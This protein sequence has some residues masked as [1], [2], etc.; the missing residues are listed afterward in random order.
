M[1]ELPERANPKDTSRPPTDKALDFIV[2]NH[3]TGLALTAM[4]SCLTL[5]S[6]AENRDYD[7]KGYNNAPQYA[8]IKEEHPIRREFSEH[9]FRYI[10]FG[11]SGLPIELAFVAYL[12][13]RQKTK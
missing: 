11:G 6:V 1:L 10:I 5:F 7:N 2:D 9:P 13:R 3:L 8:E 12:N 4:L